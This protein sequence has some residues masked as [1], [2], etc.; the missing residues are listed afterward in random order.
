MREYV[1]TA[2]Y[3]LYLGNKVRGSRQHL[4]T[5]RVPSYLSKLGINRAGVRER[6]REAPAGDLDFCFS[7]TGAAYTDEC[8]N[9]ADTNHIGSSTVPAGRK[10]S[11]GSLCFV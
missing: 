10:Q 5:S 11:L 3:G 2:L 1:D 9:E 4:R 6:K 7:L 8:M